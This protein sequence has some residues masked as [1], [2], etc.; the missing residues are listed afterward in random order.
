MTS[1]S[2]TPAVPYVGHPVRAPFVPFPLVCFTLAFA[3]DIAYWQTA[4]LMWQNFSEWLL[5]AGLVVG[6]VAVLLG[7]V[8]LFRASA[9]AV[10][11]PLLQTIA[12]LVVLALGILN[13]FVHSG[14]GWTAVVPNG[15]ITSAVTFVAILITVF[16]A[17]PR[18]YR[19]P[20]AGGRLDD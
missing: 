13:S 14:D 12:Y 19:F 17:P 10:R 18:T 11:P 15:L 2:Y 4:N 16:L 3:T 7:I 1:V 6:A 20:N 5:F 8:D 9:V